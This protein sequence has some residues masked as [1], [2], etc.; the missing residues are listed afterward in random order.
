VTQLQVRETPNSG[1]GRILITDN[2][3]TDLTRL[4]ARC[5]LAIAIA[6]SLVALACGAGEER[7]AAADSTTREPS[8][9]SAASPALRIV[10][11]VSIDTLRADHLGVYGYPRFTSPSL[12]LL[13]LESTIFEDASSTAPW[14]LP[15]HASMLTGLFPMT[16]QT[17]TISTKL[18]ERTPTLA[19]MLAEAGWETG[20]V[21]SS[22][23]LQRDPY[24]LTKDFERYAYVNTRPWQ[25]TP[26][27]W[28][29]DQALEW[30]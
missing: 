30:I 5:R 2:Q 27:T 1:G 6:A 20:A 21:V 15:S 8:E 3:R 10:I 25:K 13:A 19:G 26:N 7:P 28:I 24:N 18:D 12:D 11:L 4:R 23:W 17:V 16:H 22:R 29:T 9:S 14:T